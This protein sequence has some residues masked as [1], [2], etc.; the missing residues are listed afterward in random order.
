M[1]LPILV[2]PLYC[3]DHVFQDVINSAMAHTKKVS[4]QSI[5]IACGLDYYGFSAE[6]SLASIPE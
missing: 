3:G 5:A 2:P 4:L 6:A 1:V